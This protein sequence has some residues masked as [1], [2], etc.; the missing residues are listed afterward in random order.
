MVV[1]MT[2]DVQYLTG[3]GEQGNFHGPVSRIGYTFE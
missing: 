2:G 1:P 3:Q